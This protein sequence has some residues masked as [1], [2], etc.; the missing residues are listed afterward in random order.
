M[1]GAHVEMLEQVNE[2]H[3]TTKRKVEVNALMHVAD[4]HKVPK[5]TKRNSFSNIHE[6]LCSAKRGW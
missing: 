3:E 5:R 4:A 2:N 1:S 6:W